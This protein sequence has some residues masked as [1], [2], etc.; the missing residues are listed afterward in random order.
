M[1]GH[2]CWAAR[3]RRGAG[4]TLTGELEEHISQHCEKLLTCRLHSTTRRTRVRRTIKS[5]RSC[6]AECASAVFLEENGA[7]FTLTTKP[8]IAFSAFTLLACCTRTALGETSP[9]TKSSDARAIFAQ[10]CG[11]P[12]SRVP[13]WL[14]EP[15]HRHSAH[16]PD[17]TLH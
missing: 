2:D 5:A 13:Q 17:A 15:L 4:S 1:S 6:R 8:R 9:V 3:S 12:S 11:Y 7:P 14:L 10:S 16:S